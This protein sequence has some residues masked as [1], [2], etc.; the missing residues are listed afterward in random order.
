MFVGTL[1]KGKPA[2]VPD[3]Y[4][5]TLP[6]SIFDTYITLC[7][8][9]RILFAEKSRYIDDSDYWADVI[10]SKFSPQEITS[11]L[12]LVDDDIGLRAGFVLK[13]RNVYE[14][15]SFVAPF[16]FQFPE[17]LPSAIF[18]NSLEEFLS[19]KDKEYSHLP[20]IIRF[21][22]VEV[23]KI[24]AF[25]KVLEVFPERPFIIL[26]LGG[27]HSRAAFLLAMQF[28]NVYL[29][30]AFSS[31]QVLKRIFN[32]RYQLGN[33]L[34]YLSDKIVFASGF[35]Y[36][37]PALAVYTFLPWCRNGDIARRI[38]SENAKRVFAQAD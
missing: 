4:F 28:K 1:L 7:Q 24:S 31:K 8:H 16:S 38:F 18:F 23:D 17:C 21:S 33:L 25:R 36:I 22:D 9:D 6:V 14:S 30:T 20:A 26:S 27:K 3:G 13:E 5:S 10:I 15:V 12:I 2:M 34:T 29:N 32:N 19:F 37:R 11:L 35:P